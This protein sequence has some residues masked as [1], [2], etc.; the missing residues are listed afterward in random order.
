MRLRMRFLAVSLVAVAA[1]ILA[2]T[3]FGAPGE[4]PEASAL[5]PG[6]GGPFGEPGARAD[7][8]AFT[9]E[10]AALLGTSPGQLVTNAARDKGTAIVCF[11]GGP[12]GG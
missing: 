3:A 10:T 2:P 6:Q 11:P 1:L 12:P 5:A 8:S 4:N 7:V 9:I